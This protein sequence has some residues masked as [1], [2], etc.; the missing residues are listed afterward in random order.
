[1]IELLKK[2]EL[3]NDIDALKEIV[4]DFNRKY[5]LLEE[6]Y[7]T[8]ISK[9][10]SSRSE[11]VSD[12]QIGQQRL[13]N[14]AEEGSDL[15][16]EVKRET[17]EE[18][19]IIKEH[20]RQKPGRKPLPPEL[21]REVKEYDLPEQE[22]KC[23]CCGNE[24]PYI[25]EE[26]S[27]ELDVIPAK[28]RVIVHEK[29][30]YGPC[31]CEGFK[32]EERPE[33]IQ[34]KGPK[35]LIHGSIAAPGC[36]AYVVTGKFVD[37]LPLYRQEKIFLRIGVHIPRATMCNWIIE[38][39]ARCS[40]LIELMWEEIRSGPFIQMDETTVQVLK[41]PDRPAQSKSYMWVTIGYPDQKK[42]I[43]YH[44]HKSRSAD[45]PLKLLE[46]YKGDLQTDGYAGYNKVGSL[47]GIMHVGCMAHARRYF[48]DALKLSKNKG[49]AQVALKYIREIYKIEDILRNKN[50]P[51][52]EFVER[53]KE[54]VVPVLKDFRRWLLEK[55]E[56]VL[57]GSKLGHGISYTLSEWPKLIRYLKR[58]Y[59]T[60]DNNSCEQAVRPFVVGRK[61]WLFS[62]TMRGAYAS[63]TMY[64]L[65]E[66]AKAN[67]LE[68]YA[69]FRYLFTKLPDAQTRDEVHK[70]LPHLIEPAVLLN[71]NGD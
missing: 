9:F 25:G 29:K 47:P 8:L 60:P 12:E 46:G 41:E 2:N 13:F 36:M 67:G 22:K 40:D 32:K 33:V 58:W 70:L 43:I 23:P 37:S 52:D 71:F 35:R 38:L 50:L 65:A 59:L 68:P 57:P 4:I 5:Y 44:Y 16:L 1:M 62:D 63:A 31:K 56:Q 53:R 15:P 18:T 69:Y 45:I 55:K 42:L 64:S 49:S 11:K 48:F 66:S 39:S 27:E 19:I 24:R 28:I 10:F 3:P 34:A 7:E 61:N 6:K 51:H 30:K 20:V 26:V 54:M 17:I 21:P 14:E